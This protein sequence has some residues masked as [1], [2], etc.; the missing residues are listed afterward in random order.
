MLSVRIGKREKTKFDNIGWRSF[1]K[2][3][4][5][6]SCILNEPRPG[7]NF[8]NVLQA[9]FTHADLKSIKKT[10]NLKSFFTLSG[11]AWLKAACRTLMKST[12]GQFSCARRRE[13]QRRLKI[14]WHWKWGISFKKSQKL[15]FDIYSKFY[16]WLIAF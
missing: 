8:V 1:L 15:C 9:A 11:S 13:R 3:G 4:L 10:D 5:I 14:L 16:K 7:V 6:V 12:P 2:I